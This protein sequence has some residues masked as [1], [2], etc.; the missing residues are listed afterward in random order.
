MVPVTG[1]EQS[2]SFL[3]NRLPTTSGNTTSFSFVF[4]IQTILKSSK[5]I[6]ATELFDPFLDG[7]E[8]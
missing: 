1:Q 5:F 8:K 2:E 4:L 6:R 3:F 7:L